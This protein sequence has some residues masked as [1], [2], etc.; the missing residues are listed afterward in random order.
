MSKYNDKRISE[1][2]KNSNDLD[3]SQKESLKNFAFE[4]LQG[5]NDLASMRVIRLLEK[6]NSLSPAGKEQLSRGLTNHIGESYQKAKDGISQRTDLLIDNLAIIGVFLELTIR[7]AR[8]EKENLQSLNA[9]FK[10]LQLENPESLFGLNQNNT[11][12]TIESDTSANNP[13]LTNQ[14]NA[15]TNNNN[16]AA[17]SVSQPDNLFFEFGNNN[18]HVPSNDLSLRLNG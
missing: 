6:Y 11:S 2:L 18:Q 8:G 16:N 10:R 14:N 13:I 1:L 17:N 15:Q 12:P 5:L 7:Y 9:L 3:N 4:K